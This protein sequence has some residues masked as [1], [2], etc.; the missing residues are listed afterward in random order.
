[1]GTYEQAT[2]KGHVRDIFMLYIKTKIGHSPIHGIG[3]FADQHIPAGTTTWE[4]LPEFDPSFTQEQIDR[5]PPASRED[6]LWFSYFDQARNRYILPADNLRFINHSKIN[7]NIESTPDRDI[8]ARDI[9]PNEELLCD[10]SK[11]DPAYW[12]RHNIIPV[13]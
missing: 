4:Y 10:Y 9:Q 8:A 1:M 3:L 7:A 11:F 2:P 6:I 13:D 5:M 12:E